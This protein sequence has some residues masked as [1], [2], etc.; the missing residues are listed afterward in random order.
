MRIRIQLLI[1]SFFVVSY[2]AYSVEIN[3]INRNSERKNFI[4]GDLIQVVLK[5]YF[6][7]KDH[8]NN[9]FLDFLDKREFGFFSIIEQKNSAQRELIEI[10]G[11]VKFV[12]SVELDIILREDVKSVDDLFFMYDNTR[13]PI[14]LEGFN[15]K[16][17]GIKPEIKIIEIN[18]KK[19][20]II[21][22]ILRIFFSL[23]ILGVI[24]FLV[25]YSKKR[26]EHKIKERHRRA[27]LNLFGNINN[28]EQLE[29]LY[30]ERGHWDKYVSNDLKK[31]FY[32]A[33]NNHQYKAIWDND[34]LENVLQAAR[35]MELKIYD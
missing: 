31:N 35:K 14:K 17:S 4:A 32:S 20:G 22:R 18:L 26:R 34:D 11:R 23:I 19:R 12:V 24:L 33:I 13:I 25:I 30:K 8:Q 1:L 5:A 28:R 29:K 6:D 15:Y 9:S 21:D 2:F 16:F 3:L 27:I 10:D 7:K